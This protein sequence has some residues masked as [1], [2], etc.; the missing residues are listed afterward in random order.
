VSTIRRFQRS[1]IRGAWRMTAAGSI[2]ACGSPAPFFYGNEPPYGDIGFVGSGG[3]R[4]DGGK[5]G[6]VVEAGGGSDGSDAALDGGGAASMDAG[7]SGDRDATGGTPVDSGSNVGVILNLPSGFF[8]YLNWTISG[9]AGFYSGTVHFGAAHS[10]E[11]VV[12]GVAAGDGYTIT[13]SGTDPNGDPCTGTS[14]PFSVSPGATTGAGVIIQCPTGDG[15]VA[16]TVTTG[17]VA[18]DAGVTTPGP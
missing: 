2:A 8:S 15:A 6:G 13:L 10:L 1:L 5:G 11:F 14:A 18:V 12:G 3:G 7:V 9:P 16:A 4:L 17:S